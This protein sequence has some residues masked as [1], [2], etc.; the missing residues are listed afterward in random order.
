MQLNVD[1]VLSWWPQASGSRKAN[2][3]APLI[4]LG[5]LAVAV[6]AFA[7]PVAAQQR[8]KEEGCSDGLRDESRPGYV[9]RGEQQT[10]KTRRIERC[11]DGSLGRVYYRKCPAWQLTGGGTLIDPNNMNTKVQDNPNRRDPRS[12]VDGRNRV[13]PP[14]P[15]PLR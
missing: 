3:F 10:I 12:T 13:N 2:R 5:A 14:P 9:C 1:R 15:S 4:A 8:V 6:L 11:G 7:P